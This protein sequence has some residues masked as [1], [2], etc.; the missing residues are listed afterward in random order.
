ML[1]KLL[2]AHPLLND[3]FF[4]RSV[5]YI[6]QYTDEG[7]IGFALN[8]RTQFKLRDVWPQVKNGHLPL[9][10]GGPVAKNQLFFLHTLGE[11]VPDAIPVQDNL[12][13]G[14]DFNELL[15]L[16]DHEDVTE[17]EVRFFVGYSGWESGQ[18]EDE[19]AKGSWF[20]HE[21]DA[22][23][24]LSEGTAMLWT[25]ELE[26]QKKSYKLFGEIGFDPSQN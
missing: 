17:N 13:F 16:I 3:G 5:I 21:T 19:I 4:N 1:G 26:K 6:S 2:I 10:E 7:V 12:W 11:K 24:I 23:T 25:S 22:N 9:F 20:V 15:H 8:F 18:L 14:G